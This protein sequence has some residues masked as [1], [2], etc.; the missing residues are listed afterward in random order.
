MRGFGCW[1]LR[2]RKVGGGLDLRASDSL[3]SSL[4]YITIAIDEGNYNIVF[5]PFA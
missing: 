5:P 1:S 2:G 3:A 4:D